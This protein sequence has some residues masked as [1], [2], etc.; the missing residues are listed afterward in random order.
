VTEFDVLVGR[1]V[2]TQSPALAGLKLEPSSWEQLRAT[3]VEQGE[4]VARV[5]RE[6]E[7]EELRTLRGSRGA[8]GGDGAS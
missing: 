2:V 7:T 4:H 3:I 8:T 1:V 6:R 5:L